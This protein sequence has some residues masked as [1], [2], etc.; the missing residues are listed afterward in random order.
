M[1]WRGRSEL[2]QFESVQRRGGLIRVTNYHVK[3]EVLG[4]TSAY[5]KQIP[6]GIVQVGLCEEQLMVHT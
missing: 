5:S 3:K 1:L 4:I 2:H 6:P